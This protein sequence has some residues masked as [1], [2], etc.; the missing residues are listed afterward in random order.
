VGRPSLAESID[1]LFSEVRVFSTVVIDPQINNNTD[2]PNAQYRKTI[3]KPK[4]NPLPFFRREVITDG[5]AINDKLRTNRAIW[6]SQM[7]QF[8]AWK[9]EV[10]FD[11]HSQNG[12]FFVS[13]T[14]IDVVDEVNKVFGTY[15]VQSVTRSQTLSEGTMTKMVIRKPVIDP[16][17]QALSG[18]ASTNATGKTKPRGKAKIP[19]AVQ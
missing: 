13:D 15:Y 18:G 8:Q 17:L 19:K 16:T 3:Y 2:D 1:G 9:Y 10:S 5:E 11:T 12:A 14:L 6:R 7:A 4:V